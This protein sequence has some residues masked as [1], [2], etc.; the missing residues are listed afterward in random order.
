MAIE[1]DVLRD[2]YQVIRMLSSRLLRRRNAEMSRRM[3]DPRSS[4]AARSEELRG[5]IERLVNE[6]THNPEFAEA[7][8]R[9]PDDQRTAQI[10]AEA[11]WQQDQRDRLDADPS[12]TTEAIQ[13]EVEEQRDRDHNGLDDNRDQELQTDEVV[14]ERIDPNGN[15]E[16]DA[17]E[18]REAEQEARDAEERR[19]LE[20]QRNEEAR[21]TEEARGGDALPAVAAAGATAVVAEEVADDLDDRQELQEVADEQRDEP[22]LDENDAAAQSEVIGESDQERDARLAEQQEQAPDGEFVGDDGA[23]QSEVIGESDQERDARLAE[24]QQEQAPDGEF[25]GDDG[26][27][28]SEV[29]GESDQERDARLAEQQEQAQDGEIVGDDG[30]VQSGVIGE[31]GRG[32]DNLEQDDL[33]RGGAEVDGPGQDGAG[34]DDLE[35]GGSGVDGPG[36][37][38]REVGERRGEEVERGDAEPQP[39]LPTGG[40]QVAAAE[41][42]TDNERQGPDYVEKTLDEAREKQESTQ[43]DRSDQNGQ[44]PGMSQDEIDRM[45]GFQEGYA[46]ASRATGPRSGE[47][48]EAGPGGKTPGDRA[49][50]LQGAKSSKREGPGIG[51]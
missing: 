17:V 16:I 51:E 34:Q 33:E 26:A 31:D 42:E 40:D 36:Q 50:E 3:Q 46:D 9:L 25:V 12:L 37:D 10:E 32:Q 39:G 23:V 28:Q 48:T 29:I 2:M 45:K 35:Q 27:V 15:G 8:D 6:R 44:R 20:E 4:E 18:T 1:D 21:Q 13:R 22:S 5:I 11:Q 49:K 24:Q 38:D 7:V 43:T 47:E 19:K 41:Q 14:E 30:A